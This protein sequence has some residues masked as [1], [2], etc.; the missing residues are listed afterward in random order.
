[1]SAEPQSIIHQILRLERKLVKAVSSISC[2]R[3]E[4]RRTREITKN[5]GSL[6]KVEV[7][8]DYTEISES[9]HRDSSLL[10]L[11][12]S[13][14]H[15]S[16]SFAYSPSLESGGNNHSERL[17]EIMLDHSPDDVV[18]VHFFIK[19]SPISEA[20]EQQMTTL[21]AIYPQYRYARIE[22]SMAPQIVSQLGGETQKPTVA[23][24]KDGK[25]LNRISD[26]SCNNCSELKNWVFAIGLIT[27]C[28]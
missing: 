5:H 17:P 8:D 27:M 15:S 3:Q 16:E 18:F 21:E 6:H 10:S 2:R 14:D 11:Q 24:F 20:I 23:A 12:A 13:S 25:L 19:N 4:A 1:M 9:T 26:F 28:K 22:A 7:A